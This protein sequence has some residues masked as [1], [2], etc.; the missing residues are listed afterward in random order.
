VLITDRRL[1][2]RDQDMLGDDLPVAVMMTS[3]RP[4]SVHSPTLSPIS[5]TGTE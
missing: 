1:T 4:S 3:S 5:R 2:G